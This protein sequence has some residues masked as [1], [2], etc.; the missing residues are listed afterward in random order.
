MIDIAIGVLVGAY[1]VL[2]AWFVPQ[3]VPIIVR[4]LQRKLYE[5]K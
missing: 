3:L 2:P 4:R 1:C 5:R